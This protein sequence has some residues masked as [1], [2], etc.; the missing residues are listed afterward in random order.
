MLNHMLQPEGTL[1]R[2]SLTA[3]AAAAALFAAGCGSVSSSRGCRGASVGP[4]SGE[5]ETFEGDRDQFRVEYFDKTEVGKK[6]VRN[7]LTA[8]FFDIKDTP[9]PV[10]RQLRPDEYDERVMEDTSGASAQFTDHLNKR[11]EVR[12]NS[13][14]ADSKVAKIQICELNL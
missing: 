12:A 1:F 5:Y 13:V 3:V 10:D 9:G 6:V 14:D 11:F 7:V 2:H 4:K 8:E